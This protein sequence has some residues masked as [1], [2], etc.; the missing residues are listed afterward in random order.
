MMK[1]IIG[2]V[3]STILLFNTLSVSVF[4]NALPA[5]EKTDRFNLMASGSG[6]SMVSEDGGLVI[7][8]GDNTEI[9]FED[10]TDARE[11]LVENQTLAELLD[12]RNLIVSYAVATFSFPPQTSPIKIVILYETAVTLPAEVEI[13]AAAPIGIVPPIYEFSPEEIEALFPL[14]GE[15]VVENELIEAPAPY[16]NNG[17]VMVP[18]R[19]VAEALEFDVIWNGELR[20]INLGRAITLEIGKDYYTVG[21]MAPIELGAAPEIT[22]GLTFVPLAFFQNVVNGYDAYVFEGQVVIDKAGEMQ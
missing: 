17:V 19:A 18:L 14:N 10:G 7:H 5:V 20:S 21:R 1:K 6:L 11:R 13:G 8:V 22:D 3:V 16:Y 4:A 9:I 12:G 15:V 2:L